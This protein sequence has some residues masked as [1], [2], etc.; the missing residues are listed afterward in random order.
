[1]RAVHH[2]DNVVNPGR[3]TAGGPTD[4]WIT[5]LWCPRARPI[6]NNP[7]TSSSGE[8]ASF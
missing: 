1:M 2:A 7:A 6:N 4:R 8:T 3:V 5:Y